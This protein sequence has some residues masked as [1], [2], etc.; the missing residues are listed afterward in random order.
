LRWTCANP[1]KSQFCSVLSRIAHLPVVWKILVKNGNSGKWLGATLVSTTDRRAPA[2]ANFI[3]SKEIEML[4][5]RYFTLLVI[6]ALM[7]VALLVVR[8]AFATAAVT[9]DVDSATRSY[10]S[11]AEAAESE[12]TDSAT[13]SY[14][15]WAPL[16]QRWW[17]LRRH[18]AN[19]SHHGTVW[20]FISPSHMLQ[21]LICSK[22]RTK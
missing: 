11:W 8:E 1:F 9:S 16:W 5:H 2:G 18:A 15:A 14:T 6:T 22:R 4:A 3:R 17:R 21:K 12:R 13:H 19:H 20:P 10:T 7:A